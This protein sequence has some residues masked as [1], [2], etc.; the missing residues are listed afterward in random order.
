M[1]GPLS[2]YRVIELAGIGPGPFC[3]MVLADHGADVIRVDRPLPNA[4]PLPEMSARGRR[5]IVV[6]LKNQEGL[7]V[8]LTLVEGAHALIEGYRPGTV[9][10]LG[11]GPEVCLS[12]NPRLV[13]GRMTGW[14]QEGV[15]VQTAG[16]D[17]DY[18]A[19]SGALHAIGPTGDRSV[20]PLNLIGDYGGGGLLL[21]FGIA[22]AL[23]EAATTG[24]GQVVDAA[25][26]DGAALLMAPIYEL[27]N[28]G[29][30]SDRR[31]SNLLDG[32]APFYTTY[33]T[34]DGAQMAVGALE[35]QFYEELLQRL[36]LAQEEL[37]DR[38]DA[39]RWPELRQRL[40][41]VFAS[42]RREEWEEVFADG[43]ACVAPVLSLSE[44]PKHPHL[45]AR[46]TFFEVDGKAV[47]APAPR[48]SSHD[49]LEG[50][51]PVEPGSHTDQILGELGL[52]EGAIIKLRASGAV[53]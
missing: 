12:R 49:V 33:L 18:V 10:R 1:T 52:D 43:D 47:P 3:G 8:V 26:V 40:A 22:A 37:P 23:L 51:G 9:E 19:L 24:R 6:D 38:Q 45:R 36:G 34:A 32:A 39:S 16:H 50:G 29:L 30:W 28:L 48:F 27:F 35:P 42:R 44:A 11:L 53:G 17:I 20:P 46:R 31:G 2:G 4:L 13:Y 15:L 21:A 7:E 41:E 5:S 14:G 25:M